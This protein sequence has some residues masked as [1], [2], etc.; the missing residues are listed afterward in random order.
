MKPDSAGARADG[1]G[2]HRCA[3]TGFADGR[4]PHYIHHS[5]TLINGEFILVKF[6]I[7]EHLN[8]LKC[9]FNILPYFLQ[10]SG[11]AFDAK[12]VYFC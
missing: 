5:L 8:I 10:S 12:G 3:H 4:I 9:L 2:D 7:S 11:F 1:G 6:I